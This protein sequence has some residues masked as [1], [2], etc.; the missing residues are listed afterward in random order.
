MSSR[1]KNRTT[2][3]FTVH[4]ADDAQQPP[5]EVHRGDELSD[6]HRE[7]DLRKMFLMTPRNFINLWT[8]HL[9]VDFWAIHT[10]R[11]MRGRRLNRLY[12]AE[13][14]DLTDSRRTLLMLDY[15][16]QVAANFVHRF[17]SFVR[18]MALFA[19]A[20]STAAQMRLFG[21]TPTGYLVL[22]TH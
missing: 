11:P 15:V 12:L 22:M 17:C 3:N 7:D 20:L 1:A 14:V 19:G 2:E 6:Q 4:L 9:L 16:D 8:P 13:R 5:Y 21:N 18:S 10:I